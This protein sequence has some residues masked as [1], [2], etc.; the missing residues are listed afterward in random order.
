MLS[1][2][3]GN[4]DTSGINSEKNTMKEDYVESTRLSSPRKR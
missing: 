2:Y 1:E 3:K 4:I